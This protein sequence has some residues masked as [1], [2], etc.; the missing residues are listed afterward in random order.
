L[1]VG[2]LTPSCAHA[3]RAQNE[4]HHVQ[5]CLIVEAGAQFAAGIDKPPVLTAV[6]E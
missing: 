6:S 5:H 3:T 2:L 1:R 4:R